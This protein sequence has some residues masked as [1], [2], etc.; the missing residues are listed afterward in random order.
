MIFWIEKQKWPFKNPMKLWPWPSFGSRFHFLQGCNYLGAQDDPLISGE[1]HR[2]LE[3]T[4]RVVKAVF[5][6]DAM[7]DILSV[8]SRAMASAAVARQTLW[9]RA[10]Q[11]DIQ[12]IR[13]ISSY[14][15]QG[16]RLF[17]EALDKILVETRDKKKATHKSLRKYERRP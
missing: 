3:G 8:C 15:F 4:N 14:P 12:T 1:N 10:W 17:G 2:L 9:L 13:I 5:S 7:L 6:V 16:D 11:A